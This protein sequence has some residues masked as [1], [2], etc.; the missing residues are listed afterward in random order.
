MSDPESPSGTGEIHRPASAAYDRTWELELLISGAVTFALLQLPGAV[1]RWFFAAEP[2]MME[3]TRPLFVIAY[4]YA[5]FNFWLP[6]IAHLD[7]ATLERYVIHEFCHCL[8]NEMGEEHDQANHEERVVTQLANAFVWT[9][10]AAMKERR[11][12]DGGTDRQPAS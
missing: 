10:E 12:K 5:K 11:V 4:Q 9:W 7:D 8:V 3:S 6:S 1:D 2:R